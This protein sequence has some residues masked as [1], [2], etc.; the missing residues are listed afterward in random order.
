MQIGG[1]RLGVDSAFT[2]ST[3]DVTLDGTRLTAPITVLAIGDPPTMAAALNIPGG[4]VDTVERAGGG[5]RIEQRDR[6]EVTALR[7]IRTPQYA[8]P[9]G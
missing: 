4:V 8:R 6:V 9:A 5:V 7:T 1:V 3:G 2:G